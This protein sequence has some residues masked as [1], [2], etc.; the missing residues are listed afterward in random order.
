[1]ED[2]LNK[3]HS[4][5]TIKNILS[6]YVLLDYYDAKKLHQL[7]NGTALVATMFQAPGSAPGATRFVNI[8]NL[9]GGQ[10]VFDPQD[11]GGTLLA[12]FVKAVEEKRFL[13]T[14]PSFIS[15]VYCR[16]WRLKCRPRAK[17]GEH[18]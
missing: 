5:Y 17:Q 2:R 1:M 11:N 8:T 10:V 13:T 18:Y 3:H 6:F 15:V 12:T 9:K 14:F 7:T 4:I 16:W